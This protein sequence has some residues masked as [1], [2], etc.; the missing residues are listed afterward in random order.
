MGGLPRREPMG[1]RGSSHSPHAPFRTQA[2]VNVA[3]APVEAASEAPIE[4]AVEAPVEV[5][6]EASVEVA[7]EI[8]DTEQP[9]EVQPKI[10]QTDNKEPGDESNQSPT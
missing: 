3:E 10:E 1:F 6:A 7:S 5:A 8:R 9:V 4:V 2:K